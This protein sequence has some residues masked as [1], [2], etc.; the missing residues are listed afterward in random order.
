MTSSETFHHDIDK[1]PK[2]QIN[3]SDRDIDILIFDIFNLNQSQLIHEYKAET[4][5]VKANVKDDVTTQI[6]ADTI[7][8]KAHIPIK[9][10]LPANLPNFSK[11]INY[12]KYCFVL[13]D[14]KSCEIPKNSDSFKE[15]ELPFSPF[16]LKEF[17]VRL[18]KELKAFLEKQN[19]Y[20][21]TQHIQL[22]IAFPV[23]TI[24]ETNIPVF[25]SSLDFTIDNKKNIV[26]FKILKDFE[27]SKKFISRALG[28]PDPEQLEEI[29]SLVDKAKTEEEKINIIFENINPKKA[30]ITKEDFMSAYSSNKVFI[31]WGNWRT[32]FKVI[33]ELEELSKKREFQFSP[34][35]HSFLFQTHITN[36]SSGEPFI[37]PFSKLNK[38]QLIAVESAFKRPLTVVTGPPGTG[39]T[40]VSLNIL[41]NAIINGKTVLFSTKNNKAVDDVCKK[42]NS[43]F[44]NLSLSPLLRVGNREV[45]AHIPDKITQCINILN[46]FTK[47]S[48]L[49]IEKLKNK[50]CFLKDK[51]KSIES[52]IERFEQLKFIEK[53]LK[54]NEKLSYIKKEIEALSSNIDALHRNLEDYKNWLIE[55]SK[56]YLLLIYQ[57]LFSSSIIPHLQV[58]KTAIENQETISISVFTNVLKIFPNFATTNQSTANAIPLEREIFDILII[59]E[60][61]QSDIAS[62]LPL[63]YRSKNV[64]IIGDP[65]QLKHI[66]G[67]SKEEDITISTDCQIPSDLKL[68]YSNRSLYSVAEHISNL[69]FSPVIFLTEHYRSHPDIIKFSNDHFYSHIGRELIVKTPP[70]CLRFTHYQGIFG[71]M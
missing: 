70:E 20:S 34:L 42:F 22:L 4:K 68:T 57:S 45:L 50:I 41:A 36:T 24:R 8:Q 6:K 46:N 51:I 64:V 60:A 65:M 27:I 5:S 18:S 62:A 33:K 44:S 10:N 61:S 38:E 16:L 48:P 23:I 17:T 1:L 56:K 26:T 55:E 37:L 52:E 25:I 69:S 21:K 9:I 39:K 13:E 35:F 53:T 30:K 43:L 54:Q 28:I 67:L 31:F 14:L 58:F 66:S 7:T 47:I 3:L 2:P 11:I 12:F 49:E 15:I 29:K 63:I 19:Y 40:Q 32:N 71:F 59:D